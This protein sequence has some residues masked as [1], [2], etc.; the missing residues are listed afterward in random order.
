MPRQ[1]DVEV[2]DDDLETKD[3]KTAGGFNADG[4]LIK[5][6]DLEPDEFDDGEDNAVARRQAEEDARRKKRGGR[7]EANDEEDLE[8]EVEARLAY[9]DDDGEDGPEARGS[10]RRARRNRAQRAARDRSG[11]VIA[12]QEARIKQL[13]AGLGQLNNA[14]LN[15]HANDLDGQIAGIQGQLKTI[16]RAFSAAI[17]EGDKATIARAMELRDEAR[18]RLATLGGEKQRLVAFAQ[19][20]ANGNK[21]PQPTERRAQQGQVDVDPVAERLSETFME[22][23]PWFDPLDN[24]HEDSQMVKAIDDT[25]VNEG[26]KPNTRRYWVELERRVRSRGLGDGEGE[27]MSYRDDDRDEDRREERRE[28]RPQRSSGGL[29]PRSARGGG[30]SRDRSRDQSE[31]S[32][33]PLAR[34]TLDQL[35]LLEKAGLTKEQLAEREGYIKTWQKGLAEA[36]KAG[37]L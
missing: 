11:A 31:R 33:P 29:P 20:Q 6:A 5:D 26:Y 9:D 17:V 15:I 10:S 24:K 30:G 4:T 21:Q 8:D 28:R 22:R 32:L 27:D 25:L 14:Q 16:D 37:K 12:E 34:D 13:E 35:G 3:K 18:D 23:H 2:E 1:R 19:Q 36:R 7:V